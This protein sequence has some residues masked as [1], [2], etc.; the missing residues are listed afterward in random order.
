MG[1]TK[2]IQH[3]KYSKL[4]QGSCKWNLCA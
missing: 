3:K 2:T 1:I 4:W